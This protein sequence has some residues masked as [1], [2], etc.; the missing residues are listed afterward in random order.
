MLA[1][2]DVADLLDRLVNGADKLQGL[3]S[4]LLDLDRLNPGHRDAQA[5]LHRSG[6]ADQAHC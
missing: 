6:R 4:D 2:E 5:V 3:L 1:E